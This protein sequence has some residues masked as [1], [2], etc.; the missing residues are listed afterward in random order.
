MSKSQT[1]IATLSEFVETA[2]TTTVIMP[3][4]MQVVASGLVDYAAIGVDRSI[5]ASSLV[6]AFSDQPTGS[7]GVTKTSISRMDQDAMATIVE[8][9]HIEE[10]TVVEEDLSHLTEEVGQEVTTAEEVSIEKA[11]P[12]VVSVE[13]VEHEQVA[14]EEEAGQEISPEEAAQEEGCSREE[15]AEEE[16]VPKVIMPKVVKQEVVGPQVVVPEVVVQ[17]VVEEE[18]VAH[19]VAAHVVKPEEQ[20]DM[21]ICLEKGINSFQRGGR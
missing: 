2:E 19:V 5:N 9:K 11:A 7:D 1:S 8:A 10:V 12:E 18:V 20:V 14:V 6:D 3:S 16:A 17:K 13:M 4:Q 15:G 21:T